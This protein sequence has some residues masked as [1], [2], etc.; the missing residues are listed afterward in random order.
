MGAVTCIRLLPKLSALCKARRHRAHLLRAV[1]HKLRSQRA[2][3]CSPIHPQEGIEKMARMQLYALGV[4]GLDASRSTM[5]SAGVSHQVSDTVRVIKLA[6]KRQPRLRGV[7]Y[8]VRDRGWLELMILYG[9]PAGSHN[10]PRV[11]AG[12]V[13]ADFLLHDTERAPQPDDIDFDCMDVNDRLAF[14]RLS[15]YVHGAD[16]VHQAKILTVFEIDA[17]ELAARYSQIYR[18]LMAGQES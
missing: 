1:S 13:L 14:M 12:A 18:E 8:Q 2:A 4:K 15:E 11:C 17:D 5:V 7:E 10:L 6:D 16:A 9:F 3:E